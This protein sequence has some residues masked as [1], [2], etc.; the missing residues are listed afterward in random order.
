MMARFIK[1]FLGCLALVLWA[2]PAPA[3]G[4]EMISTMIE[5]KERV[6]LDCHRLPNIQT[7]EGVLT[8]QALCLECHSKASTSRKVGDRTF[9]L[10]VTVDSFGKNRHSRVACMECHADVARSP[11]KSASG[12]QC[13]ACHPVH[14]ERKIGDPH[15]RVS[16]Q[17]CHRQSK[18]VV[19]DQKTD[20][21]KLAAFD[22][23]RRPLSLTDHRLPD[24]KEKDF[25]LKCHFPTNP[26]GASASVLPG[27]SVLCIVCHNAPMAVGHP[28]FW[29]ALV[30][31]IVGMILVVFFW[32]QGG[33]EGEDQTVQRKIAFT[34]DRVWTNLFSR[35]GR[36]IVKTAFFDGLLQRRLLQESVERW[37]I[38]SLIFLSFLLRMA[39]SLFTAVAYRLGP[40]SS[41]AQV[42][43]DKN[44]PGVAF[45][46]DLLGLLILLGL[47]WAV[48]RRFII[49]PPHRLS[50]GQDNF[51]LAIIGILVI[52]GFLVEGARI[53]M[54]RIPPEIGVYS[55]VG[56]PLSR[57]LA[58]FP[59]DW[60]GWYGFLWWS[61]ALAGAVFI[62]S[63]PF[64][65][66]KHMFLTPLTL[67]LNA[68][69]K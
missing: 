26:V 57:L 34:S 37:S 38:H 40:N 35:E 69:R 50:E 41:L 42:L 60:Q 65:K 68:K 30:V 17:A 16:C 24:T 36:L 63:I 44:H 21:V 54:T 14:G 47:V 3:Q 22:Q 5:G 58:L 1:A 29:A 61:H 23:A 11:H 59:M 53:L 9:P 2:L 4:P 15:L 46:Y 12:A 64:G 49:R 62:A 55:F 10:Q 52:L 20:R 45:T 56:Y 13:Q 19:L 31:F 32:F 6:C 67:I 39:L 33:I 25:C 18:L 43:I 8:A 28:V 51:A 48:F 7:N 66:M 27:K